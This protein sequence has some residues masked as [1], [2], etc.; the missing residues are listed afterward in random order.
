MSSRTDSLPGSNNIVDIVYSVADLWA[1]TAQG[2]S[3][4]TLPG[5]RWT[6]YDQTDGLPTIEVPS[7]AVF[8]NGV[9]SATSHTEVRE[10]RLVTWGDGLY[11]F[12]GATA[13]WE[14]RSPASNQASGP[15]QLAYDLAYFRRALAAC[16]A[17]GLVVSRT[18]G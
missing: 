3:R 18:T 17:G 11:R 2:P 4:L 13:E 15:F 16:F 9:W 5:D 14:K 1:A 12:N 7:L 6:T 10:G 8:P